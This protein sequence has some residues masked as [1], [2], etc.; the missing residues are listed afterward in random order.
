M[1]GAGPVTDESAFGDAEKFV[2][3][4]RPA[5]HTRYL[6]AGAGRSGFMYPHTLSPCLP[7]CF[8]ARQIAPTKALLAAA[9]KAVGREEDACGKANMEAS[10]T[11]L[12][13]ASEDA[14]FLHS[15]VQ[16]YRE[17]AKRNRHREHATKR[18]A[19]RK[20]SGAGGAEGAGSAAKLVASDSK[21]SLHSSKVCAG[22]ARQHTCSRTGGCAGYSP[23][24]PPPPALPVWRRRLGRGPASGRDAGEPRVPSGRGRH[25][26]T[27]ALHTQHRPQWHLWLLCQPRR[28]R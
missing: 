9:S 24:P 2:A 7:A 3:M 22:L 16:T 18:T 1:S 8:H 25:G 13:A 15:A 19:Q 21:T 28:R 5:G 14:T 6:L 10:T 12:Q 4:V 27:G 17:L 20:L 23:K 11:R 26:R